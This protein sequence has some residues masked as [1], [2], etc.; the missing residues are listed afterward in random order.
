MPP[1]HPAPRDDATQ[2][3]SRRARLRGFL[4]ETAERIGLVPF[5]PATLLW[6]RARKDESERDHRQD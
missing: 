3:E 1:D 6:D 5:N 2:P 4:K